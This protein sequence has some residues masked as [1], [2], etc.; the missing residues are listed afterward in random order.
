MRG[1]VA[2]ACVSTALRTRCGFHLRVCCIVHLNALW[3]FID[4]SAKR[5]VSCH[6]ATNVQNSMRDGGRKLRFGS[7]KS[8]FLQVLSGGAL[9]LLCSSVLSR[10]SACNLR[11][12]GMMSPKVVAQRSAL[13]ENGGGT[14]NLSLHDNGA[15][16][17][18]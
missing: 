8:S 16:Y 6:L 14:P 15:R 11:V 9:S 10:F 17:R 12:H 4:A 5:S 7:H 13:A 2:L 3:S 1:R 18:G